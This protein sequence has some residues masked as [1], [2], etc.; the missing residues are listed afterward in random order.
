MQVLSP[1]LK[2]QTTEHWLQELSKNGNVPHSPIN[3]IDKVLQDSQVT[4]RN[5]LV[6]V[7]HPLRPSKGV[8]V[9]GNPLKFSKTPIDYK[10]QER[11]IPTLGTP[12]YISFLAAIT[13]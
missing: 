12:L 13:I 2:L 1:L 9:L 4:A 10:A 8:K 11:R 5:M 3:T 7:P 6:E